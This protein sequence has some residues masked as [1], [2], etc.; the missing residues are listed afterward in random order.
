ME[1]L[2]PVSATHLTWQTFADIWQLAVSDRR[3]LAEHFPFVDRA[4]LRDDAVFYPAVLQ[5]MRQNP[6]WTRTLSAAFQ[7]LPRAKD[8]ERALPVRALRWL[9]A[10]VPGLHFDQAEGRMDPDPAD[11]P[12]LER[13]VHALC[14]A[15]LSLRGAEAC[16]AAQTAADATDW[17]SLAL[18]MQSILST[19]AAPDPAV[20]LRLVALAEDL[21]A[22][23]D[24]ALAE[25]ER[26]AGVDARRNALAEALVGMGESG[27]EALARLDLTRIEAE[28]LPDL[29]AMVQDLV[30]LHHAVVA[31]ED[32]LV[33]VDAKVSAVYADPVATRAEKAAARDAAHAAEDVAA[34]A[35]QAF[36]RAMA[37]LSARIDGLAAAA[38]PTAAGV[39]Q[40]AAADPPPKKTLRLPRRS[41]TGRLPRPRHRPSFRP[42]FRSRTN[43]SPMPVRLLRSCSCP[44]RCRSRPTR[45]KGWRTLRPIRSPRRCSG[46]RR[47]SPRSCKRSRRSPL[48]FP[49]RTPPRSMGRAQSPTTTAPRR[50]TTRPRSGPDGRRSTR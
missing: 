27:A 37:R 30:A 32:R 38:G 5:E 15:P 29:E 31:A 9:K 7:A 1:D 23:C 10:R 44:I 16:G 20:A 24:A 19:M 22:A 50:R 25:A 14:I 42:S 21:A 45:P 34:E 8:R 12:A 3:R 35:N 2:A 4:G 47:R 40:A 48:R 28:D 11:W 49:R 17:E 26:A 41:R 18:D 6:D 33:E 43:P 13:E 39:A 46:P 36:G